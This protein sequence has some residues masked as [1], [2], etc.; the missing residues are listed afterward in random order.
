MVLTRRAFVKA[1]GAGAALLSLGCAWGSKKRLRPTRKGPGCGAKPDPCRQGRWVEW[2]ELEIQEVREYE[3]RTLGGRTTYHYFAVGAL[4]IGDG[5]VARL[6]GVDPLGFRE[7]KEVRFMVL[8]DGRI[9][10]PLTQW[11]NRVPDLYA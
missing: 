1:A 10:I 2:Q 9:Q 3:L 5:I 6:W 7:P 8:E 4:A 11:G